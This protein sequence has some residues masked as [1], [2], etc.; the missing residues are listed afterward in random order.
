MKM[1]IMDWIRKWIR[2]GGPTSEKVAVKSLVEEG[3]K[4]AA[5]KAEIDAAVKLGHLFR[6]DGLLDTEPQD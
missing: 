3:W 2:N 6:Y 1:S 5:V 4:R